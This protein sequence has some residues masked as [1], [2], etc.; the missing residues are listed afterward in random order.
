MRFDLLSIFPHSLDSYFSSSI[1]AK[2]QEKKLI[3]IKTHDIRQA[4]TD[5][6]HTVDDKPYGGGPGM[7][8]QIEPVYKTL[9]KVYKKPSKNTRVILLSPRGKTFTQND[10]KRLAN[11]KRL[12]FIAGHYESID[13]RME[14]LV[15][16]NISLGNFVLTGG[17]LA[18][19]CIIDS[20]ARLVSGVVGKMDSLREESFS[21]FDKASK[22]F[23]V[24]YPQYSRPDNFRGLK[25]PQVLLS[26]NHGEIRK[27]RE[28][29]IKQR[30]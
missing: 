26:G 4:S 7:V 10:V 25:V 8:I 18:A 29:Q 13:A 22:M 5:K 11:Y 15:D 19:A 16:E 2:A 1:L 12:I 21:N 6:R 14:K 30:T 28:K 23:N 24:E 27:W 3:S 9:K 17:E 20:V